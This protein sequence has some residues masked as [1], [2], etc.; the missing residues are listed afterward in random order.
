MPADCSRNTNG[1]ALP[2]MIGDF[3]A[4][5]VDVQIVDAQSRE[6]RHQV[7]HRRNSRAVLFQRRRKT[8]VADVARIG[9]DRHRLGQVRA[10]EDNA[11]VARRGPQ[12][13]LDA[14]A[15]MQPHPGRS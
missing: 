12:H 4:R 8:R 2:S 3:R 9:R 11:G 7:L 14:R 1:P 13:Q 6:R 10:M 15:R 5:D